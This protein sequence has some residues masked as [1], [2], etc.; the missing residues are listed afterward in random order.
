[1]PPTVLNAPR[2]ARWRTANDELNAQLGASFA[3]SLV[4]LGLNVITGVVLA[5]A[6]GPHDRGELAAVL[7]WP[8]MIAAVGTLG[9]TEATT[10]YAAHGTWP[11]GRLVGTTFVIGLLQSLLC[12]GLGVAL[13]PF[14]LSRY[15]AKVVHLAHLYLLYIPIFVFDVYAMTLIQGLQRFNS[16]NFLRFLVIALTAVSLVTLDLAHSL[17][18]EQAVYVYLGSYGVTGVVAA[19]LLFGGESMR[20]SYDGRVMREVLGFGIR[21]HLGNVSSL[22][23]ERL[24]Q[25]IISIFLAPLK[26]GLYVVAVSLTSLTT[27]PGTSISLVALPSVARSAQSEERTHR[28]QR[29]LQI[30]LLTTLCLTIPMILLMAPIIG[31]LFGSAFRPVAGVARVLLIGSVILGMNRVLGA[32]A[33]GIGRPL[34][35]GVAEGLALIVTVLALAVLLPMFGLMGAA[36]ASLLAYLASAAWMLQKARRALGVTAR[37]LILPIPLRSLYSP[38]GT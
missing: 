7:L 21:S 4:I 34:D 24:D 26:L 3:T 31:L 37:S 2:R 12:I 36:V 20:L 14:V 6:L 5:R 25:L 30:T 8:S 28:I 18:V 16:F 13:L 9:V 29:L 17:G 22:L 1:V 11:L 23:N 33:R 38:E 27:L 35:A 15:D 10:Y 32:V 19:L